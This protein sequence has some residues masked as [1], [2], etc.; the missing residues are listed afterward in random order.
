MDAMKPHG[1]ALLDYYGGNTTIEM[2]LERDDGLQVRLPV[3][4]FFR[5]PDAFFPLEDT[6]I[7]LCKGRVLDIGA[8]TGLHALALQERGHAVTAQ[9][10]S[11]EAVD[12]MKKCGVQDVRVGDIFRFPP[13]PFD[14]LLLLGHGIGMVEN[15]AGLDRFLKRMKAFLEPDGQLIINSMDV[16]VT[17]DPQHLS[18]HHSNIQDCRYAGEI[19]LRI[20]YK[21]LVGDWYS[22]LHVDAD[23]LEKHAAE[24]GWKTDVI[25][26]EVD[27]NYLA[28]LTVG[29]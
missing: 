10:I 1:Q 29:S 2:I 6:A 11:P 8:G 12:V 23:T 25:D 18:Y 28:R 22:W 27:G 19:R 20:L 13:E 3:S 9:D 14:T 7:E 15:L 26:Q 24:F 16:T 17:D 5:T 21:D 4:V